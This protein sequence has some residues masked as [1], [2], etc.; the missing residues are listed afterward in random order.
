MKLI[1]ASVYNT[2]WMLKN[3]IDEEPRDDILGYFIC[4]NLF[5]IVPQWGKEEQYNNDYVARVGIPRLELPIKG[6]TIVCNTGDI[7]ILYITRDMYSMWNLPMQK[8]IVHYLK[9]VYGIN[10]STIGNDILVDNKKFC[11]TASGFIQN[12]YHVFGA[13]FS[14]NDT[15]TWLINKICLKESKYDG[16]VGLD[17]YNVCPKRFINSV[18]N[19]SRHWEKRN[20]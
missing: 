4:D 11:G 18:I 9:T 5:L 2:L 6:G 1:Q 17:K 7:G 14:M 16:F 12:K 20:L 10:A 19:F 3:V 8:Y 13:F 15:T